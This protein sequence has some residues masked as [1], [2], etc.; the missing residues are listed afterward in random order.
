MSSETT[1][2]IFDLIAHD[3]ASKELLKATAAFG[4]VGLAVSKFARESVT[5]YVEAEKSQVA[6]SAAYAKFPK[7]ADVTLQS[8]KDLADETEK[9]TVFDHEATQAA[10][11]QLAMFGLTGK[12]IEQL[13]PLVQDYAAK[14]GVDLTTAATGVGR[15]L[16][17]NARALKTIG[18]SFKATG[19]TTKDFTRLQ[20]LLN[21]KVG[22]FAEAQGKTA[23]GQAQI[24]QHQYANLQETV[25]GALVPTLTKLVGVG[26]RVLEDFNKLPKPVQQVTVAVGL[27]GGAALVLLPR[28]TA[29]KAAL[30]ELGITSEASSAK[31]GSATRGLGKYALALGV[32]AAAGAIINNQTHG[33]FDATAQSADDLAKSTHDLT[34]QF[35]NAF[36]TGGGFTN[37]LNGIDSFGRHLVGAKSYTDQ[38]TQSMQDLDATMAKLAGDG[39]IGQATALWDKLVGVAKDQGVSLDQLKADFPAYTA[40]VAAASAINA[41]YTD[42]VQ[43]QVV[44]LKDLWTAEENVFTQRLDAAAATR[45]ATSDIKD[46]NKNTKISADALDTV[47]KSLLDA[48]GKS[49]DFRNNLVNFGKTIKPGSALYSY[50]QGLIAQLDAAAR[51]RTATLRLNTI[52]TQQNVGEKHH[53]F[54]GFGSGMVGVGEYGRETVDLGPSPRRIYS[55]SETMGRGSAGPPQVIQVI[56]DGRVLVQSLLNQQRSGVQLVLT[57]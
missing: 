4:G 21:D 35:Q 7:L 54:G 23:A 42:T 48:A 28:I 38:G 32:V 47:K 19:D 39:K 1:S 53:A 6:L 33:G 17:G 8:L 22:G 2:L 41:K 26:A 37:V 27:L 30:V 24:L 49:G 15:A 57:P 16:L 44:S 3:K 11:A 9:K 18:I 31:V 25:G 20:G 50:I 14:T 13:I 56:L 34:F 46:Y 40:A 45:H 5:A 51:D 12:Q 43:R 36:G 29:A 10:E 55:Q 52:N